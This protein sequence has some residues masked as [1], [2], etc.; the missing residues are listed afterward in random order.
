MF[1]IHFVNTRGKA[2]K[3]LS[4]LLLL[5][6][7]LIVLLRANEKFY[8]SLNKQIKIVGYSLTGSFKSL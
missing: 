7:F 5:V 1:P 4:Y 6:G 2:L 8:K 3:I